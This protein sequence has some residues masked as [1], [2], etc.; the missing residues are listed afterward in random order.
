MGPMRSLI[1]GL[2]PWATSLRSMRFGW[3]AGAAPPVRLKAD[4][5]IAGFNRT[6]QRW[7]RALA[8]LV[9]LLVLVAPA[10]AQTPTPLMERVT[11][12]EAIA[13]ALARNPTLAQAATAIVRAEGFLQQ[14]RA[15]T[16][17]RSGRG[18]IKVC[19][20]IAADSSALRSPD[21]PGGGTQHRAR[22]GERASGRAAG[23]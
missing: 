19:A 3:Q 7:N 4:T 18:I 14:A 10:G 5:T 15:A 9:V 13:R 6:Y 17:P 12:D 23:H 20:E 8:L 1:T 21:G 22:A 16:R 11:F 2:K